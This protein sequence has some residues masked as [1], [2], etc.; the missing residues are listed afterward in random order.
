MVVG[1][2]VAVVAARHLVADDRRVVADRQRHRGDVAV[3]EV[4]VLLREVEE[5]DQR[6]VADGGLGVGGELVREDGDETLP[7]G[8]RRACRTCRGR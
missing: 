5:D 7:P 8:R 3:D 6:V 4:A 1:A 2:V